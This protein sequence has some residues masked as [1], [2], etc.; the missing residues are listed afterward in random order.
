M[1][2]QPSVV[3]E[4]ETTGAGDAFSSGFLYGYIQG[5]TIDK[6]GQMGARL[7]S[8]AVSQKGIIISDS[9]LA[10]FSNEFIQ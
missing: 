10:Q 2:I 5:F 8:Y 7:A 3:K 1:M 6:C 9:S 4:P